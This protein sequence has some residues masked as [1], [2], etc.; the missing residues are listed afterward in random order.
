MIQLIRSVASAAGFFL[1]VLTTASAQQ[2]EPDHDGPYVYWHDSTKATVFYLCQGEINSR[3]FEDFDTLKFQRFCDEESVWH[4]LLPTRPAVQPASFDNVERIYVVSDIHGEYEALIDLLKVSGVID[5]SL[6]WMWA[7]GHLVFD[8]D[9]FDRGDAVTETL[10]L[11]YRLEQEAMLAGG[12]VHYLLGN[13]E[14]MV[15]RDDNR[16][17]HEKYIKGTAKKTRIRHQDLFGPEMELGR[18]LRTKNTMLK[19]NDLL[20][21]HG[22]VSL[23][24]VE[25]QLTLETI[26]DKVRQYLDLKSS[27]VVFNDEPKFLFGSY[28][29]F[30]YRGLLID[31][32]D[33]YSRLTKDEVQSCLDF[34]D[35]RCVILGHTEMGPVQSHFDGLVYSV[36]VPLDELG[37][38]QALLWEDGNFYRVTGSGEREPIL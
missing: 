21:V 24:L 12:R 8:G 16:Y 7:D 19:L 32:D 37:T 30:W 2:I 11:I 13:H 17:V 34:Y 26:N 14:L 38:L 28:G 15:L 31:M 1:L 4:T 35:A 5:D 3:E 29:P 10:W 9:I 23:K 36:D 20:F 22:G 33:R 25:R 27:Q 18:W 6:H